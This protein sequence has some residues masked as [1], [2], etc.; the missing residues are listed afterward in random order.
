[1]RR[2]LFRLLNLNQT[3]V[4]LARELVDHLYKLRVHTL[5]HIPDVFFPVVDSVRHGLVLGQGVLAV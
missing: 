1:M 4:K 5:E 2:H 3:I